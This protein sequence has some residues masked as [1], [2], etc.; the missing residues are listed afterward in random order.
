MI[1]CGSPSSIKS[2]FQNAGIARELRLPERVA[3]HHH[4]G[5]SRLIFPRANVRPM[6]AFTP[7]T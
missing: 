2:R 5:R 1:L 6:R 7:N 3:Q 4:R